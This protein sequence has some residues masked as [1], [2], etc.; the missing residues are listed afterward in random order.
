M[1]EKKRKKKEEREPGHF[2][3]LAPFIVELIVEVVLLPS[4]FHHVRV[5]GVLGEG[6]VR[7]LLLLVPVG[8][9]VQALHVRQ[10][11]VVA[12]LQ[13]PLLCSWQR[14]TQENKDMMHE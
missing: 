12:V 7:A 8:G 3:A 11:L 9:V 13:E 4:P 10:A 14:H 2:A 5:V 1:C 6:R